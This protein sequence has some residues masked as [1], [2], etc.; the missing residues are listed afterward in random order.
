M[1][2]NHNRPLL[3]LITSG[4]TNQLTTSSSNEYQQVLKLTEAAVSA[5]INLI[6]IR[7]KNLTTRV[8]LALATQA[9]EITRGSQ[10]QLLIND[11]AD[12]AAAAGADG[13]H[14]TAQSLPVATV[15][16]AFGPD[17]LIGVSTHSLE[18]AEAAEDGGAD[19]IVFGPVFHTLSKSSY[20]DPV[21]IE[22]LSRITSA[23]APLPVIALGGIDRDKVSEC[24]RAGS[25]GVAAITMFDQP[26]SMVELA[27]EVRARFKR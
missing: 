9:A 8:L 27:R 22:S 1:P 26:G 5:E 23:M 13:V 3:Y 17:L 21:G 14:L 19:F 2:L 24:A 10:T 7:E 20:G 15:R 6:Q 11:R 18:E 25:A 12:V 16:D 4:A